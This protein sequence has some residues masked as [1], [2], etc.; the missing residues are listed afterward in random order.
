ML[1]LFYTKAVRYE[2]LSFSRPSKM[3]SGYQDTQN[4]KMVFK[5]GGMGFMFKSYYAKLCVPGQR[6]LGVGRKRSLDLN[7]NIRY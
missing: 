3:K 2:K 7:A 5:V 1:Y 4:L 6:F